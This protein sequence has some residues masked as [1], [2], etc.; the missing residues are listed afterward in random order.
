[1]TSEIEETKTA[2]I[3]LGRSRDRKGS[4]RALAVP[5]ELDDHESIAEVCKMRS[6]PDLDQYALPLPD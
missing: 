4:R 6:P 2:V 1:M 5:Q 3:D